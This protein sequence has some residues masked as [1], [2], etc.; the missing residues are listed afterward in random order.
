MAEKLEDPERTIPSRFALA[1]IAALVSLI[2]AGSLVGLLVADQLTLAAFGAAV[3]GGLISAIFLALAAGR[4]SEALRDVGLISVQLEQILD[5]AREADAAG[6][7]KHAY[8]AM[9][10]RFFALLPKAR[11]YQGMLIA[12]GDTTEAEALGRVISDVGQYLDDLSRRQ[13][14]S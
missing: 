7:T 11:H 2:I 5:T 1:A 10:T 3:T 12:S 13:A 6:E 9:Q 8:K 4:R 14:G